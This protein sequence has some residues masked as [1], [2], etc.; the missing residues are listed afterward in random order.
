V[1]GADLREGLRRFDFPDFGLCIFR[2]A[3][4]YLAIRC[5]PIGQNGR[6]GH[7]HNDQLSVVL[8]LDGEVRLTDP[9][10]YLY[11]ALPHL[12]DRYR[13]A[14][15]HNAP[16]PA[17]S[18]SIPREPGR[19]DLGMFRLGDTARAE[20][21]AADA[22]SF[23]GRHFGYGFAVY[24]TVIIEAEAVIL[25]DFADVERIAWLPPESIPIARG[26]GIR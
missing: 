13:S 8:W 26:Y 24:R 25:E 17:P 1:P 15:V 23:C 18:G 4:V 10:T 7:A 22:H 19:L 9:G 14:C 12:R 6:G 16:R 2:S 5:G 11:T 21:V 3:R 20:W